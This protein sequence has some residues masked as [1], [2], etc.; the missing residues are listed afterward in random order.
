MS[1]LILLPEDYHEQ[2]ASHPTP[3]GFGGAGETAY[4]RTYSRQKDD[5]SWELYPETVQRALNGAQEIGAQLTADEMEWMYAQMLDLKGSVSGRGL[6]QLGTDLVSDIGSASLMNCQVVPGTDFPAMMGFL[7]LGCGVGYSIERSEVYEF[8][9][10]KTLDRPITHEKTNDAD[11]IVPDS[12]EGWVALMDMVVRAYTETGRGFS[13]STVLVRGKGAPLGRF[14]GTASGPEVLVEGMSDIVRIF[15]E[16]AQSSKQRLRS[17][18]VLDVNTIIGKIVKAGNARRSAEIAVGDPDDYLFA[19]A[20][21][22]AS[23]DIPSWRQNANISFFAD[24]FNQIPD[25]F[26]NH[27][28]DGDGEI[29]GL[30]NRRL[31]RREGRIGEKRPDR[32]IICTNPCGEIWLE[33]YETCNLGQL[34]LPNQETYDDMALLAK[35][36]YK[37]QKATALYG[38][39]DP[40]VDKVM[41]RNM[42]LGLSPSG[43]WQ[44]SEEQMSWLSPCYEELQGFDEIWSDKLGVAPSIRLTTVQPDGT[45]GLLSGSTPG[46]HVAEANY[47]I[48]RIRIAPDHGIMPSLRAR[49]Y[50]IQPDVNLDG[51]L[52]HD[53]MVVDFPAHA[54][55]PTVDETSA[56]EQLD[57][58]ARLQRE[59]SDNS[60]SVTIKVKPGEKEAIREWMSE[61]YTDEIKSVSFLPHEDHGFDLAP[62]EP[63]DEEE[64]TRLVGQIDYSIPLVVEGDNDLMD[65]SCAGGA[66]PVR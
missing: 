28:W 42:R 54:N 57:M 33:P 19:K 23:G 58:V 20:K 26:W 52:N 30:L 66:C 11:F 65:E 15:D 12:R 45:K 61:H 40:R 2:F 38:H 7:M 14:G 50:T 31:A 48:R 36:V 56:V 39:H 24:T 22:W 47:H 5:G 32:K 62:Y 25:A 27:G 60:V 53:Q 59:W 4:L 18:D 55:A 13:Y 16:R 29:H 8:A 43:V 49:G 9:R 46:G 35:T 17:I 6:W 64:Y 37:I 63:I 51:T 3:W 21:N 1:D 41:K 34:V 10:I 44:A